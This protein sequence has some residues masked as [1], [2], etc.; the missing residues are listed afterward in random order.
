MKVFKADELI[1]KMNELSLILQGADYYFAYIENLLR[2][3]PEVEVELV[4]YGKWELYC[5]IDGDKIYK[6]S[7]CG[8]QEIVNS[9]T[10][11]SIYE[12]C[13]YC[14]CGLKMS[15]EEN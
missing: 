5:E 1:E 8:R 4:R 14:H 15:Y 13:P 2:D 9:M 6:C 11:D 10:K 3:L 12:L 7:E